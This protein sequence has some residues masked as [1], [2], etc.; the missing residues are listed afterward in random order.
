MGDFLFLRWTGDDVGGGG[1]RDEFVLD[2]IMLTAFAAAVAPEPSTF[3]LLLGS[4]GYLL[5]LR[6][7]RIR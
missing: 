1:S 6:R 2:N 5:L 3:A 7:H 4:L